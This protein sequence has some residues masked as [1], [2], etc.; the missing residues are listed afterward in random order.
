MDIRYIRLVVLNGEQGS[1][2]TARIYGFYA[3]GN[4]NWKAVPIATNA[5]I[6]GTP[7]TNDRS[8][9]EV[10]Y[11]YSSADNVPEG[12]TTFQWFEVIGGRDFPMAGATGKSIVL[13]NSRAANAEAYKCVITVRDTGGISNTQAPVV[14]SI[15][16]DVLQGAAVAGQSTTNNTAG[17]LV[18]GNMD[19]KWDAP[20]NSTYSG[21]Q[22]PV[23]VDGRYCHW[24]SFD[25]GSSKPIGSVKVWGS[26]SY[27]LAQAY[28]LDPRSPPLEFDI[29]WS[30]DNINWSTK[31]VLNNTEAI[32]TVDLGGTVM[33]RYVKITVFKANGAWRETG[34]WDWDDAYRS[35]RILKLEALVNW[36]DVNQAAKLFQGA[37]RVY[38]K[39]DAIGKTVDVVVDCLDDSGAVSGMT[40]YAAAYNANGLLL[41]VVNGAGSFAADGKVSGTAAGFVVPAGTDTVKV[42]LW[43]GSFIPLA[44]AVV[45]K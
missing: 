25:M 11:T 30:V 21:Y 45:L 27:D 7:M 17:N 15:Y 1:T 13:Q 28:D 22:A 37:S 35:I 20:T 34:T 40:V 5:A 3:L 14:F 10:S 31:S 12:V 33:A 4:P 19:T 18:N 8:K 41:S 38:S 39:N 44:Q 16:Q 9:L 2:N 43:D 24:A 42:F 23:L 32:A 36:V 29:S 6:T 26:N